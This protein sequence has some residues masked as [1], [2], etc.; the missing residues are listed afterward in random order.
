VPERPKIVLNI[1]A[2]EAVLQ[3]RLLGRRDG[4]SDDHRDTV[5]K[6]FKVRTSPEAV[7]RENTVKLVIPV[8]AWLCR[9]F[10]QRQC[11]C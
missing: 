5:K 7:L 2:P 11:L 9:P 6:R 10:V 1:N 3:E 4:R 8:R